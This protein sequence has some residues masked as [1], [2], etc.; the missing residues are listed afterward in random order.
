M[1]VQTYQNVFYAYVICIL[2]IYCILETTC[3]QGRFHV[4]N[5]VLMGLSQEKKICGA[6]QC[7]QKPQQSGSLNTTFYVTYAG[8]NYFLKSKDLEQENW[9]E[10]Y[11]LQELLYLFLNHSLVPAYTPNSTLIYCKTFHLKEV[12]TYN[13][14]LLLG[15]QVLMKYI[16]TFNVS[17]KIIRICCRM[18]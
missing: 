15:K 10:R 1:R 6:S 18:Y 17:P 7:P 5:Q 11:C 13:S 2:E 4:I 14:Y 8:K 9:G 12:I 16:C 3:T